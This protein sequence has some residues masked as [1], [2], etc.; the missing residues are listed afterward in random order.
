MA[1]SRRRFEEC[2]TILKKQVTREQLKQTTAYQAMERIGMR[3]KIGELIKND[4]PKKKYE[5]RQTQA[6]PLVDAYFIWLHTLEVDVDRSSKIG[7]GS[8]VCFKPGKVYLRRYLEDGHLS[9]DNND[10][11]R[12]IKT[13]QW[14]DTTGSLQKASRELRP[15]Q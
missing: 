6:K 10:Y 3:Y 1:H 12:S 13:L 15:A 8:P 14:G 9:I 7:G 2:L 5:M 4:P 11:E